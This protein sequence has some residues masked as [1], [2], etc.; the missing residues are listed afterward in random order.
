MNTDV[1]MLD[2]LIPTIPSRRGVFTKLIKKVAAQ[3]SD[4]HVYHPTLGEV[5]IRANKGKEFLKGGLSVGAKRQALLDI[6]EAKYICFLDDDEDIS[7]DY[8]ETILRLC[9]QDKDLC[10]FKSFFKCD[11]YW[12]VV[13]MSLQNKTN[14]EASPEYEIQRTPW[15]VCAIRREKAIQEKFMDVNNNEDYEWFERVLKNCN[16]EAHSERII[17]NY[18][19]SSTKSEVDKIPL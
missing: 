13:N 18:N 14:E 11:T 19:H 7:P 16:D 2:V 6:S 4:C 12:S 15:H 3:A 9:Y 1:L 8:I 5:R 10:T 17:H